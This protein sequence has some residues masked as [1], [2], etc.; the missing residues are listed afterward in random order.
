MMKRYLAPSCVVVTFDCESQLLGTSNEGPIIS[1][2]PDGPIVG[3]DGG[4]GGGPIEELV[5]GERNDIWV[6]TW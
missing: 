3:G 4:E 2:N 1:T 6:Q 5:K